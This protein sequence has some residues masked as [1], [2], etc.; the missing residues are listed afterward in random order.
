MASDSR[1][2]LDGLE[3]LRGIAA[4]VVVLHHAFSIVALP[5]NYNTIL[6]GNLW[7]FKEF[8]G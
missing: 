5:Q 7:V 3:A 2:K 1:I 6:L 8:S 4:M